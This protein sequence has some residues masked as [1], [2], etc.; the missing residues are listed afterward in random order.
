MEI[1]T[2]YGEGV[3]CSDN[4]SI[5]MYIALFPESLPNLSKK[6]LERRT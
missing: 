4:T 1:Y 6:R 2:T 3:V 5:S